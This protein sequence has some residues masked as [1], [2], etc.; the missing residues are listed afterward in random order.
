MLIWFYNPPWHTPKGLGIIID[1]TKGDIDQVNDLR[2]MKLVK[3]RR[4]EKDLRKRVSGSLR[5][6]AAPFP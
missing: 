3:A 4:K 5:G 2:P 6:N 1:E